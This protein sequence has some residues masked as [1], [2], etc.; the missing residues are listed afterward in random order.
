MLGASVEYHNSSCGEL[1]VVTPR[2]LFQTYE[3]MKAPDIV[4]RYGYTHLISDSKRCHNALALLEK[5]VRT[6][7]PEYYEL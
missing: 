2:Y 3:E 6:D 4:K 7:Y 5:R 1:N